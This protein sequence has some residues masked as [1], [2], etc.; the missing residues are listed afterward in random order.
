MSDENRRRHEEEASKLDIVNF[1]V[2]LV[3]GRPTISTAIRELERMLQAA[4]VRGVEQGQKKTR[5]SSR[6]RER[7]EMSYA[8]DG[9]DFV[10]EVEPVAVDTLDE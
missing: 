8:V 10:A 5:Y 1:A 2:W 6:A 7:E 4:Y 3:N 9:V